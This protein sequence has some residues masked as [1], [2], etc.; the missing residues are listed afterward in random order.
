MSNSSQE[1]KERTISLMNKY[2]EIVQVKKD[3][4]AGTPMGTYFEG[5]LAGLQ[6]GLVEIE[7]LEV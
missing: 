3:S 7:K 5:Y 6:A 2:I 4:L 1:F